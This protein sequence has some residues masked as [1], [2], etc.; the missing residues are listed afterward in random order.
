MFGD[1]LY[2][3]LEIAG[4]DSEGL[5]E[6]VGIVNLVCKSLNG[7]RNLW[8]GQ[9]AQNRADWA[10]QECSEEERVGETHFQEEIFDKRGLRLRDYPG[11]KRRKVIG[12]VESWLVSK[13]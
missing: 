10:S 1:C 9:G 11:C 3:C 13:G 12:R 8:S 6:G 5:G 2:I 4:A 7:V